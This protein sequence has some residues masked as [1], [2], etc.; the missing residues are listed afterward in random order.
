MRNRLRRLHG[1]MRHRRL[2]GFAG[3]AFLAV[4]LLAAPAV[5][6]ASGSPSAAPSPAPDLQAGPWLSVDRL[7]VGLQVPS[8]AADPVFPYQGATPVGL[9]CPNTSVCIAVSGGNAAARTADGG[10]TWTLETVPSP[11]SD[12]VLDLSGVACVTA[13]TCLAVGDGGPAGV[14]GV[15]GV[16]ASAEVA[17]T[18]DGGATWRL[19]SPPAGIGGL[20]GISCPTTHLCVAVGWSGS[21]SPIGSTLHAVAAMTVDEGARWTTS[22]SAATEPDVLTGVACPDTTHCWAVGAALTYTPDGDDSYTDTDAGVVMAST[23]GGS[24]W[25]AQTVGTDILEAVACSD[26]SHCWA[27]GIRDDPTG[28]GHGVLASTTDGQSWAV[29]DAPSGIDVHSV[30]C[31]PHGGCVAVAAATTELFD[32]RE[33]LQTGGV[34]LS[35]P[36][37]GTWKATPWPDPDSAPAA[38]SCPAISA[39]R[40]VGI[41]GTDAGQAQLPSSTYTVFATG[42]GSTWQLHTASTP[43]P[44]LE[45]VACPSL[46]DCVAVGRSATQRSVATLQ[47]LTL[48]TTDQ[49]ATWRVALAPAGASPTSA[50]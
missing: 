41:G 21:S 14:A 22:E 9:A 42:Y 3:A 47:G 18:N 29:Q 34:I 2:V 48:N 35:T 16:D 37:S 40:A 13:A 28:G 11:A 31:V 4:S 23:D 38:V 24:T 1:R 7:P 10:T 15:T 25:T 39:C 12:I 5:A 17:R 33:V 49:G 27:V 36:G 43:E 46:R 45:A 32:D 50:P 8:T 26:D 44:W 19:L 30:S 20:L 6:A